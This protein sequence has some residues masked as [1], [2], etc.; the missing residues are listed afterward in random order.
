PKMGTFSAPLSGVFRRLEATTETILRNT[1]SP[2]RSMTHHCSWG[3]SKEISVIKVFLF[4]TV[5]LG[6]N[7]KSK[8]KRVAHLYQIIG[9]YEKV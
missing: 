7:T 4:L 3:S 5:Y 1:A 9:P 2:H 8:R 6:P